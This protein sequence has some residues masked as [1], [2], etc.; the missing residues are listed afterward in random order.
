MIVVLFNNGDLLL[1]V[2]MCV[3]IK[4]WKY[5]LKHAAEVLAI[6]DRIRKST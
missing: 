2:G 6:C 3:R 5:P 1:Q 4:V